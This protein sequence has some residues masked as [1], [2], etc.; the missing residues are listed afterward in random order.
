MDKIK[1][2]TDHYI[3]PYTKYFDKT[4]GICDENNT[5]ILESIR[6]HGCWGKELRYNGSL[7]NIKKENKSAIFM[8]HMTGHYGHFLWETL[9]RFWIF[10]KLDKS[11]FKDKD[12]VF[13]NFCHTNCSIRDYNVLNYILKVL[14]IEHYSFI[15]ITTIKKYE[16]IYLPEVM[17]SSY[18][19]LIINN[20]YDEKN[21]PK[22]KD[23]K[24]NANYQR[25]LFETITKNITPK[26][27][28]L[29]IYISRKEQREDRPSTKYDDMFKKMGFLILNPSSASFSKDLEFYKNAR[30]IA[31]IDGTGLHN[32][33]FMQNPDKYMIEL[34]HR[35]KLF[36]T[37]TKGLA[38]GQSFFNWFNNVPYTVIPCFQLSFHEIENKIKEILTE[39]EIR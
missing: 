4:G 37:E 36:L 1:L 8:G 17:N 23:F 15:K 13:I 5:M 29:K 12:L 28:D 6:G 30:I 25:Q 27:K 34:K 2:F 32:V 20:V 18:F 10:V 11:F 39:L 33:G 14:D 24:V 7:E 9:S 26:F 16:K 35:P 38:K 31:G 21:K 19:P 3:I 22:N